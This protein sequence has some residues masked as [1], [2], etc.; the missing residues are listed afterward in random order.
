VR[1][2]RRNSKPVQDRRYGDEQKE[3]ARSVAVNPTTPKRVDQTSDAHRYQSGSPYRAP[4]CAAN[5]EVTAC[6][7]NADWKPIDCNSGPTVW[8]KVAW[9]GGAVRIH[10]RRVTS[11]VPAEKPRTWSGQ[12]SPA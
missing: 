10:G 11:G 5:V 3:R 4:P 7:D 1:A 12:Y 8:K 9:T 2:E 6:D